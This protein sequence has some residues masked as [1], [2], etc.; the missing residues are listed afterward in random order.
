[1][2]TIA[3]RYGSIFICGKIICYWHMLT[4][5]S[6]FGRITPCLFVMQS[7]QSVAD[8]GFPRMGV[9]TYYLAQFY[10]Q[11]D[12]NEENRGGGAS[13]ICP[14]RIAI[15][16]CSNSKLKPSEISVTLI[17]LFNPGENTNKILSGH[18]HVFLSIL[19]MITLKV[20]V[21]SRLKLWL[22]IYFLSFLQF[23]FLCSFFSS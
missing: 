16:T 9:P 7:W 3:V 13:D 23:F 20:N 11:L 18:E 14:C 12:E 5:V 15:G 10:R 6:N 4:C 22:N 1:M 8:P 19:W 21:M 17:L 2:C